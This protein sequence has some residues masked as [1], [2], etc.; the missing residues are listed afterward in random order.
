MTPPQSFRETSQT[1]D[2]HPAYF[3]PEDAVPNDAEHVAEASTH[4]TDVN[5]A[6]GDKMNE[7]SSSSEDF[8]SSNVMDALQLPI[9]EL[10]KK[11][12]IRFDDFSDEEKEDESDVDL[13]DALS[14]GHLH[15][16]SPWS[17]RTYYGAP[18]A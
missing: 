8:S 6:A 2:E 18:A 4:H 3:P 11:L 13:F 17:P 12:G 1:P 10:E 9:A 7:S 5:M 16:A 15:G 14:Q